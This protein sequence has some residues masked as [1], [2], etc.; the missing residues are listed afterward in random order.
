MPDLL[1]TLI[2]DVLTTEIERV[3]LMEARDEA[4]L[5]ETS[6]ENVLTEVVDGHELVTVETV[7]ELLTE[8]VQGPPGA[9]SAIEKTLFVDASRPLAYVAFRN[10]IVRL[11]YTSY[12]PNAKSAT[13]ADPA[14]SWSGRAT[15][16]YV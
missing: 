12:P 3:S 11:D 2:P 14:A 13:V 8:G 5:F 1:T 4:D 16:T 15:L 10:R 7:T 6:T 9:G